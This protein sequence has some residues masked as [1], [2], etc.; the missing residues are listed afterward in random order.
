MI[1]QLQA[2]VKEFNKEYNIISFTQYVL[3]EFYLQKRGY[4][5]L[6]YI[7]GVLEQDFELSRDY[8]LQ[9]IEIAE[10]ENFWGEN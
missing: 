1:K 9:T 2:T 7:V 8:I 3:K 4:G 6:Y 5:N 10:N